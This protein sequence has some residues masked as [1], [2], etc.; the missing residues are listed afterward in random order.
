MNSKRSFQDW[1][2][3]ALTAAC[4]ALAA[5]GCSKTD[6]L[7]LVSDGGKDGKSEE[8]NRDVCGVGVPVHYSTPGCGSQAVPICGAYEQDCLALDSYCGC[9][10][11]T[12]GGGGCSTSPSPFLY[13]G[14]CRD[15]G[16]SAL[17]VPS[18]SSGDSGDSGGAYQCQSNADGTC[19]AVTPG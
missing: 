17:D 2:L 9:D 7:G 8:P 6:S 15:G 13:V 1:H 3:L 12:T 18:D 14:P 5:F 4:L 16:P 10:G 11:Q 19:S